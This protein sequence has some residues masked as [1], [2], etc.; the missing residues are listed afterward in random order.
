MRQCWIHNR[1]QNVL[2]VDKY[3]VRLWSTNVD[4]EHSKGSECYL[5]N[6]KCN[7]IQWILIIL[8]YLLG[9]NI[10]FC[11]SF[12]ISTNL[13]KHYF[14]M[15]PLWDSYC[16][17]TKHPHIQCL[18]QQQPLMF[19]SQLCCPFDLGW[20]QLRS[21]IQL[22]SAGLHLSQCQILL[23]SLGLFSHCIHNPISKI[24]NHRLG[25]SRSMTIISSK[26]GSFIYLIY[27]SNK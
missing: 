5:L 17:I 15:L 9:A 10:H 20:A 19:M 13:T 1:H 21:F 22:W 24:M 12:N 16:C 26:G 8:Y 2:W 7:N 11:T 14:S 25:P 6:I 3:F 4:F 18:K 23:T 27:S